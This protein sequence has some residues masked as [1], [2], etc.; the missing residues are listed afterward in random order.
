MH[1]TV[2][3]RLKITIIYESSIIFK[4]TKSIWLS[5]IQGQQSKGQGLYFHHYF[6]RFVN[7]HSITSLKYRLRQLC[8]TPYLNRLY[9]DQWSHYSIG[10]IKY[11]IVWDPPWT[12]FML[13]YFVCVGKPAT[14][15]IW[16][17][18]HAISFT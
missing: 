13:S 8:I 6:L 12:V 4:N 2:D 9:W 16:T 1:D 10:R 11:G 18:K 7:W 15:L 5:T 14:A 3:S 17:Q